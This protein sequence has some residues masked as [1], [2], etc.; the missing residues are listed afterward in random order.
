MDCPNRRCLILIADQPVVWWLHL[1]T[2]STIRRGTSAH[3]LFAGQRVL[4]LLLEGIHFHCCLFA[5]QPL[6]RTR[7]EAS[8][9]VAAF[10]PV[11]VGPVRSGWRCA[12]SIGHPHQNRLARLGLMIGAREC[13]VLV[14][15]ASLL[16]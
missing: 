5:R 4:L 3:A 11:S 16:A 1:V 15:L 10:S 6:R 9:S 12:L 14:S 7:S 2:R 13:C 8:V